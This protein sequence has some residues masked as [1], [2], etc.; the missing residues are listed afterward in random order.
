MAPIPAAGKPHRRRPDRIRAALYG[1]AA[2]VLDR[3]TGGVGHIRTSLVYS[4]L[5]GKRKSGTVGMDG[6]SI[7]Y[8]PYGTSTS[9]D[10]S[11]HQHTCEP[12]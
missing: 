9:Q 8:I 3:K 6:K 2:A 11:L 10:R 7:E 12:T 5:Y 4:S 1:D